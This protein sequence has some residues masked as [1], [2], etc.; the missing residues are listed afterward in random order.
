MELLRVPPYGN[1]SVLI[2]VP[3]GYSDESFTAHIQDMADLSTSTQQANGSTGD[4]LSFSLPARYDTDYSIELR[5]SNSNIIAAE[6]YELRRPYSVSDAELAS[7]K[8]EYAQYEEVSR[9][10]IDSIVKQGF[11][12]TKHTLEQ[13][14]LGGDFLPLWVDAKKILQVYENN[15]LVYD[16]N[17]IDNSTRKYEIT[18]DKSAIV[19][20]YDGTINR[21]QSHP[22]WLPASNSDL[23]DLNYSYRG[24]PKGFD[25][26]IVLEVGYTTVPADI[27]KASA[28]L[29]DDIAC[30]RLEYYKRYIN[31]Y[32]TDQFKLKFDSKSFDGTGNILVDKILTKYAK[33]VIKPGV[34]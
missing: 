21:M 13:S 4:S 1:K 12:Y 26:R 18:K 32:N 23:L 9:A 8:A 30:G 25:Y 27:K 17:D 34:F 2:E 22:N 7:E 3:D 29:T 5:D 16:V 24:F 14:G 28:M 31:D 33:T 6:T 10:V 19:E 15:V 11:Y 20:V